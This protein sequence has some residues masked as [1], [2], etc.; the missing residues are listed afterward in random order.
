LTSNQ[1]NFVKLE[2]FFMPFME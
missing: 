2:T 1:I